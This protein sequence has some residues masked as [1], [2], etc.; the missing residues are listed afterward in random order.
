M[1]VAEGVAPAERELREGF[2]AF[3]QASLRLE[4][5]YAEL[6]AR[7]EAV[8][9]QL[10]ES[11]A[12]LQQALAE[13][14]AIVAALPIGLLARKDEG[15]IICCNGEAERLREIAE[16]A[17][18]DLEKIE[19]GDHEIGGASLRVRSVAMP[20]GRLV[21]LEDRTRMIE[22]EREVRRLDRLA[23]L[24]ELALG[25]AHEIKNPLNGVMGFASLL[26]RKGGEAGRF[27]RRIVDGLRQ[28]DEIVK[29]ML[30]FARPRAARSRSAPLAEIVGRACAAAALPR[31]SVSLSGDVEARAESEALE[32]VLA[33]LFRNSRE[34]GARSVNV[35][36]RI[37]GGNLVLLV[38]DDGPGVPEDLGPRMMEPFMTTKERG[39]GLGLAIAT[40]VLSF[41]GGEIALANPGEAG[42]CFR[43]RVRLPSE[44]A[45]ASRAPMAREGAR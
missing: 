1:G 14:E 29:G 34:A 16:K 31:S 30:S 26:Q 21:L 23:G 15:R 24:S 38:R 32:R 44:P 41:L 4:K 2:E 6:K 12:R 25:V 5:S 40:R 9:L 3:V 28:I 19:D 27:A 17:G 42:A 36:S 11:N 20:G 7:A 8:D 13:R 33:N 18:V 45:E 10:A 39:S 43:I 22:L 37:D 35:E